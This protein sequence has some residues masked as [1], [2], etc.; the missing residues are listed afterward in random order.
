MSSHALN[1]YPPDDRLDNPSP[2]QAAED[3][4]RELLH[5]A[6]EDP[7]REGLADTPARMV[8][9]I[10][11]YF[12]G[13]SV[14][15]VKQL[16]R[17]FGETAGYEDIVLLRDISFVSHCEHHVAPIVGTAHVAYVPDGR[18]A[19]ISKLA[20]TVETFARRLQIQERMTVQ[21][22]E[23]IAT[24]LKPRGVAVAI[25]AQHFCMTARG[26]RQHGSGM[27]TKHLTGCFREDSER[28]REFF[29]SVFTAP[30]R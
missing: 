7:D 5:F 12:S 6:G 9:A 17:T 22:A 4:V 2:R 11:E 26:V 14:D 24:A 28:R 20:R 27:V 21:I 8:R 25:E 1:L 30:P 29:E 3:A 18:V 16:Q 13:Y 23:A 10:E 15:P 19:G